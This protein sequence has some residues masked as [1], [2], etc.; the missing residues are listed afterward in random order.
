MFEG[1]SQVDIWEKSILV[2]ENCKS[3]VQRWEQPGELREQQ[4]LV[5]LVWPEQGEHSWR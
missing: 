5:P 1:T 4:G 2:R 3:H